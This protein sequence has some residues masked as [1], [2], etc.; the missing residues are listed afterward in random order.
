MLVQ[1]LLLLFG[2]LFLFFVIKPMIT[3]IKLKL[4]FGSQCRIQYNIYGIFGLHT[5]FNL[6]NRWKKSE[7]Q[8][9][10]FIVNNYSSRVQITIIDPDY[11]KYVLINPEN[12]SKINDLNTNQLFDEG[13]MFQQG[14]KWKSQKE[15]C[16]LHFDLKKLNSSISTQNQI[17]Q[18]HILQNDQQIDQ[19]Q[20]TLLK[21]VNEIIIAS[22]F[23][24]DADKMQING[25]NI[26]IETI[27][28]FQN[29]YKLMYK[30]YFIIKTILF[31]FQALKMFPNKQEQIIQTKINNIKLLIEKIIQKRIVQ[32]E[33]K[34][35]EDENEILQVSEDFLNIYIEAYLQSKKGEN[36]ISLEE[37]KQQFFTF[38][39]IGSNTTAQLIY[40][41]LYYLAEYPEIQNE[42]R[43]EIANNCKEEINQSSELHCLVHLN[44]FFNEVLR[45]NQNVTIMRKVQITHYIKD[46]R[47]ERDWIVKVDPQVINCQKK[48]F[49][50]PLEF[51]YK[52]WL[53]TQSIKENNNFVFIPFSSGPKNCVG[54]DLVKIIYMLTI[55]K[56]MRN[57]MI[58]KNQKKI[59]NL[60]DQEIT[61]VKQLITQK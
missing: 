3:M 2:L 49:D 59:N 16:S 22:F 6:K 40:S 37:I 24:Q 7:D 58:I 60:N 53:Q 31:G 13:I 26:G 15:L 61:F 44:A 32:H 8:N 10:K 48:Y 43:Q 18:K 52:R 51:N 36:K 45:L 35:D 1:I 17:I 5:K 25:K 50:N 54:Q 20:T 57:F 4:Q 42:L 33:L 30:P 12:F 41:S 11:Y 19:I 27:D 28:L 14:Q 21:I 55:T 56:I 29:L 46:L 9:V 39:Y 38:L 34:L 47:L 23:G